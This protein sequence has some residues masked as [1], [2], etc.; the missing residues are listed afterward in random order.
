LWTVVAS[1][2]L[3]CVGAAPSAVAQATIGSSMYKRTL[4]QLLEFAMTQ[5]DQGDV[6]PSLI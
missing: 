6:Q 1:L 3:L 5:V 4:L 2:V